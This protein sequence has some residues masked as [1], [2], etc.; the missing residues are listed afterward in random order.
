LG[1]APHETLVTKKVD[2]IVSPPACT[3]RKAYC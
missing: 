1:G 3:N 2:E